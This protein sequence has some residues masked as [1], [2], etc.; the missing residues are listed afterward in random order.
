MPTANIKLI[1]EL[2][3]AQIQT[4]WGRVQRGKPDEC[5]PWLRAKTPKGYGEFG[6]PGYRGPFYAHRV[7]Y[8][9]SH[10]KQPGKETR[11]SCDFRPCCNPLHLLSGDRVGNAADMV[12]RGRSERGARH[13]A[14]KLTEDQVRE[15]RALRSQGLTYTAIAAKFNLTKNGSSVGFIVTR[16]L[17]KHLD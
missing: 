14:A 7:A 6:I 9:L 2:T 13:H 15:I 11:H 8:F 4:F 17:W 10:G 3:A 16:K 5:W 1:P 12:E